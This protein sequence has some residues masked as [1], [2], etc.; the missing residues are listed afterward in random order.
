MV[1][2]TSRK[3]SSIAYV[4]TRFRIKGGGWRVWRG[5]AILTNVKLFKLKTVS[6]HTFYTYI[7]A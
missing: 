5:W 6:R 1:R 2:T 3:V 7:E 4:K